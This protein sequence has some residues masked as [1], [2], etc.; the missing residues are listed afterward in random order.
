MTY[1]RT[2]YSLI[3]K[4][5]ATQVMSVLAA[6][7]PLVS[8]AQGILSSDMSKAPA[9]VIDRAKQSIPQEIIVILDRKD[10]EEQESQKRYSRGLNSNDATIQAETTR[11]F[12]DL[13]ASV[14]PNGRLGDAMVVRDYQFLPMLFV[15]V[16]DF[17]A[18]ARILS[19][20]KVEAV[21]AN[22]RFYPSL[23]QSLPLIGQPSAASAGKIGSGYRVAVIDSGIWPYRDAVWTTD[24]SAGCRFNVSSTS[25]YY[26][27][28]GPYFGSAKC[29]IS[30]AI[31]YS[32]DPPVA[33]GAWNLYDTSGGHGTNVA[34]IVT[35]T[36]P[37]VKV[38]AIQVFNSL[39]VAYRD[40]ILNAINWVVAHYNNSPGP[41]V[42]AN[43]SFDGMTYYPS[44][45]TS[46]AY[47]SAFSRLRSVGILP[48]VSSGNGGKKNG[49]PEPSCAPG[50]VR[51]GSVYDQDFN[52]TQNWNGVCSDAA[53]VKAD[54]VVCSSNSSSYLTLLA[55]GS[56]IY[57]AGYGFSGTSQAAPH[58][59]GAVAA[60][61]QAF[62]SDSIDAI[63]G[64]MTATGK[65]IRDPANNIAKPRLNLS[66][67]LATTVG[68]GGGDATTTQIAVINVVITLLVN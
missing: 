46:S 49:L 14:F 45:C 30:N 55:P 13:K 1:M 56:V 53:P 37:G 5:S 60:L 15:R 59:S 26:Y 62:P 40:N 27:P 48:V 2:L 39:G 29:R 67:A 22:D 11:E 8:I 42:A 66:A 18:L 10:I 63:T 9:D 28:D 65:T 58:V 64:R 24:G 6:L 50:A 38:D 33:S 44:E 43:L 34:G 47:A 12:A 7:L 3:L 17:R 25:P 16:P 54:Q 4:R 41:I 31:D 68:S 61:K 52:Y 51:V 19:H 23:Q 21:Q 36:A 32:V 35:G 20:P 57:A